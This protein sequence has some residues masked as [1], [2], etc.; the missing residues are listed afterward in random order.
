MINNN[1]GPSITYYAVV[2]LIVLMTAHSSFVYFCY[3]KLCVV[4]MH[5]IRCCN[6]GSVYNCY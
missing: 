1:Q 2:N 6:M 3:C 5:L 4:D